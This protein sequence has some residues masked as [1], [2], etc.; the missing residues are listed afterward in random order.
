MPVITRFTS[1]NLAVIHALKT[2]CTDEQIPFSVG[3]GPGAQ[4]VDV[5]CTAN[6]LKLVV[7]MWT[8]AVLELRR[9]VG[10]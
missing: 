9:D 2:I 3:A 6:H 10:E 1:S 4:V 7:A 8:A 5:E